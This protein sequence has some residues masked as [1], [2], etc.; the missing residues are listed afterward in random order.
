MSLEPREY[1]RHI[2]A[3]ATYLLSAS[4]G[5]TYE[6]FIADETIVR[7]SRAA[8]RSSV[9]PQRKSLL[10]CAPLILRSSGA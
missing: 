10:K 2:L 4:D 1:L 5:L 8:W 3:E 7:A 6:G 9:R